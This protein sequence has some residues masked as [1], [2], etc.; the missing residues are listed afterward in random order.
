MAHRVGVATSPR[1]EAKRCRLNFS[2]GTCGRSTT[3]IV[4]WPVFGS[5]TKEATSLELMPNPLAT[6]KA[7]YWLPGWG[8]P[9]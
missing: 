5:G 6:M 2:N 9:M 4:S 7:R 1:S 3:P 8:S